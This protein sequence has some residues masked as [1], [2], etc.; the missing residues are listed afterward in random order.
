M[1]SQHLRRVRDLHLP[2][3]AVAV[4]AFDQMRAG[5]RREMHEAD[6]DADDEHWALAGKTAGM[7][8]KQ[9]GIPTDTIAAF[10]VAFW[11]IGLTQENK[12]LENP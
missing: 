11:E 6:V 7:L 8:M 10:L 3:P 4:G 1:E 2:L 5:L 9:M 12:D